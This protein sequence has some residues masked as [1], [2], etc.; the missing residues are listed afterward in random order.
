MNPN[1]D[2]SQQ[3]TDPIEAA[4]RLG[5]LVDKIIDKCPEAVILVAIVIPSCRD[6]QSES[7]AQ[8]QKLIPG[9][10]RERR[11]KGHRVLAADFSSFSV[12]NLRD[13]IHPTNEGYKILGNYWYSFIHQIPP[14]WIEEPIGPNPDPE[15]ESGG[16][17]HRPIFYLDFFGYLMIVC[18]WILS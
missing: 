4:K 7:I 11:D 18:I 5:E 17:R 16:G 14:A 12:R 13:C 2:I 8:Y 9:V 1:P 10:V 6:I 15:R 3:G